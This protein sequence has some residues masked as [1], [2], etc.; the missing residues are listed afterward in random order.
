MT[1]RLLVFYAVVV[2][3]LL[4][5]AVKATAAPLTGTVTLVPIGA[6][7]NLPLLQDEQG[8]QQQVLTQFNLRW[9]TASIQFSLDPAAGVQIFFWPQAALT[10]QCG[11]PAALACH[12]ERHGVITIWVM[13]RIPAKIEEI[14]LDHEILEM[15]VDPHPFTDPTFAPNGGDLVEVCDPVEQYGY[16]SKI[17]PDV[18]LSP[19]VYPSYFNNYLVSHQTA[20]MPPHIVNIWGNN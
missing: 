5:V 19:F 1:K 7:V 11:S 10:K 20:F 13:D 17:D 3:C 16:R 14:A 12:G 8:I 9:H 4:V 15:L 6:P 18:W 2:G